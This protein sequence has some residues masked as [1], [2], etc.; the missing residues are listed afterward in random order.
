MVRARWAGPEG[1]ERVALHEKGEGDQAEEEQEGQAF[2]A[3]VVK[4]LGHGEWVLVGSAVRSVGGRC[5]RRARPRAAENKPVGQVSR[6][7]LY[8]RDS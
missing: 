8:F 3:R 6:A 1:W 5:R 4:D 7:S 2:L